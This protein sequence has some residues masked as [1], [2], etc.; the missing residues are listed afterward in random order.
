MQI[1]RGE[2][3][4]A[5]NEMRLKFS[6]TSIEGTAVHGDFLSSEGFFGAHKV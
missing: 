3:I 4:F 1:I 6:K 2:A 5:A